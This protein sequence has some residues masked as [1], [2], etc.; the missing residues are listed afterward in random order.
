MAKIE[1]E[2]RAAVR[3]A[4]AKFKQAKIK[5]LRTNKPVKMGIT[6]RASHFADVAAL[7]PMIKRVDGLEVEYTAKSM[8]DAYKVFELLVLASSGVAALLENLQ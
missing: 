7:L 5:P 4:V 8:T 2:L 3:K 6:F 1:K